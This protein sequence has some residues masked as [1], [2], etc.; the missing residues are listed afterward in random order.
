MIAERRMVETGEGVPPCPYAMAVLGSAGRGESLLAMDQDNAVIFEKGQPGGPEDQWFAMLGT[1]VADILH[2]VGVPYCTGGVMASNADWRGSVATWQARIA[3]WI[4]RSDPRGLLAADIFFDM[5][6]VYGDL[7]L[8]DALWRHAYDAAKGNAAFAKLLVEASGHAERGIGF[9]GGIRTQRG[10][11]DLKR[12]GLFG[13]VSMA[14]ALAICHHILERAT[15]ARLLGLRARDLGGDQDIDSLIAAHATFQH[16][17]LV[18][19]LADIETGNPATNAVTVKR[20]SAAERDRLKTAL[21]AVRHIDELMR[22]L[23][24]RD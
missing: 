3:N 5:R 13:I 6:G 21:H 10:R 4:G 23:L 15:P 19:Q 2:E 12:T 1:R 24:F 20:L 11:V 16:F 18:Q 8:T 22:D 14:R 9:F 7:M 17:I